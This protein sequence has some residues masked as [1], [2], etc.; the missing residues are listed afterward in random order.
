MRGKTTGRATSIKAVCP[1]SPGRC[2]NNPESQIARAGLLSEQPVSFAGHLTGR[3]D[4]WGHLSLIRQVSRRSPSRAVS[5]MR[6]LQQ[7]YGNLHLQRVL[8]LAAKS[9]K[10]TEVVPGIESTIQG[11]KGTGQ[12]LDSVARS[13]METAFGADFSAV[14]VHT[15]TQANA[16]SNAL[17]AR[18]FTTGQDIFFKEGEYNPGSSAGRELLAH[19][20]THVIQQGGDIRAKLTVGSPDDECEMEADKIAQR[21]SERDG[22]L[23]RPRVDSEL[24]GLK[25]CISVASRKRCWE[26]LPANGGSQARNSLIDGSS[27]LRHTSAI[28][29]NGKNPDDPKKIGTLPKGAIVQVL[30]TMGTGKPDATDYC[31]ASENTDIMDRYYPVPYRSHKVKGSFGI[32]YVVG[33]SLQTLNGVINGKYVFNNG[34]LGGTLDPSSINCL[35]HASGI[36]SATTVGENALSDMI[37]GLGFRCRAGDHNSLA[38]AIKKKK[39]VMMVYVYMFKASWRNS[40]DSALSYVDL[41][42]K[43]GWTKDSWKQKNVFVSGT[44]VRQPVDYHAI[45]FN[46]GSGKWEWVGHMKPKK[47]DLTYDLDSQGTEPASANPDV[48]FSPD[49]VLVSLACEK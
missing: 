41:A 32:G 44:G 12:S 23:I 15:G 9:D 48:Y 10:D 31:M 28:Q 39:M 45:T 26:P 43:Y 36:G 42:K 24:L 4:I 7:G 47:P 2:C 5:L 46:Y 20:L 14:R 35:G 1:R 19:E 25:Q 8:A 11:A 17:S 21:V 27:F 22:E 3:P 13:R 33:G 49:Q 40:A 18:A 34:Q 30:E 37:M 29:C 16:L 38:D 6:S